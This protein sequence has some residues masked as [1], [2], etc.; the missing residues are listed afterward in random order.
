MK[1]TARS[2]SMCNDEEMTHTQKIQEVV[3]E[4]ALTRHDLPRG[5]EK[6]NNS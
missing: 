3:L 1:E 5:S 4:S 2:S 6:E